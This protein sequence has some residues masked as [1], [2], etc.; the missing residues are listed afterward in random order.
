MSNE[1]NI[2]I[3]ALGLYFPKD[4]VSQEDLEKDYGVSAGKYT[5]GL[6]QK[7]MAVLNPKEDFISMV[8]TV[9]HNLLEEYKID[10]S[11]V[12]HIQVGTETLVDKS[13]SAKTHLLPLFP[14]RNILGVDQ[15]NA[16]YGGTAA[17]FSAVNWVESSMYRANPG[18]A[19]VVCGDNA[20]YSKGAARPTGGAGVVAMLIGPDAP[21]VLDNKN[22]YSHFDHVWDFYKPIP[23]SEYPVV[24]GPL[25]NRC[26][27]E[28]LMS[29]VKQG[30]EN[31]FGI[32]NTDNIIFH[33]PYGKL[34]EKCFTQVG[35]FE[36]MLSSVSVEGRKASAGGSASSTIELEKGDISIEDGIRLMDDRDTMKEGMTRFKN[37][38]QEKVK[39]GMMVS[40]NCGNLY[41]GSVYAALCSTIDSLARK[42]E[43]KTDHMT[44]IFSYGSGSAASLFNLR[45][46][47]SNPGVQN[48]ASKLNIE[49]KLSQ[50]AK[51]SADE[52]NSRLDEREVAYKKAGLVDNSRPKN[53]LW[54]NT[55]YLK[56]VDSMGRR[57][58]AR[59]FSTAA[60]YFRYLK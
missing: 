14:H 48:I 26:Y 9:T 3:H 31:G 59:A 46:D 16:C 47:F 29:C 4:Y 30:Y 11:L 35:L 20:V 43:T 36:E 56:S 15:Y 40:E 5:I 58:Y 8:L 1:K 34:V 6:G 60:R 13:K 27:S 23:D 54:K 25:S 50:R 37:A 12:K 55:Y 19:L 41:T 22:I 2:G 51:I 52:F 33:A 42:G 38:F 21:I 28:S 17:L 7:N 39:P 10:P 44:S 53:E 49:E 18:Y 32:M 57:K 24:D 45:T